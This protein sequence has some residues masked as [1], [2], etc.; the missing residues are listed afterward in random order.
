MA[1][2]IIFIII[3]LLWLL[4][5]IIF[6]SKNKS[7]TI[8]T[9]SFYIIL[10][11]IILIVILNGLM[12]YLGEYIIYN[13]SLKIIALLIYFLGLVLRYYSLTLL[14]KNFS[15][16]VEVDE[17][18]ELVSVGTYKYL[19]HPL[20]LGLFLLVIVIPLYSGNI[21]MFLI[22]IAL[23]FKVINIRIKEEE[24]S[25]E[26]TIGNRYVEWKNKRYKFIPFIY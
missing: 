11:S 18:Q 12:L 19:R 5:F 23:M 2:N 13:R 9:S 22:S 24:K 1:M 20:Y 6:P 25:M 10:K 8:K 21:P 14:G 16:N 7:V 15:R 26:E 3:T 4:E 17:D